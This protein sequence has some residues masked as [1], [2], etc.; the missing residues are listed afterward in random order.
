MEKIKIHWISKEHSIVGNALG[1]NTHN[2]FM[3]KH[4]QKIMDFDDNADIT[5]TIT[6]ADQFVPIPGKFNILFTMWEFLELPESYIKNLS[7]PDLIIVPSR[8]CKDLFKKYT[9]TPIEVCFEGVEA[10][11]YP[12]HQR[13]N[14]GKFRF[15]WVGAPNPRK[16]YPLIL[17]AVKWI[18]QMPNME[19]YIK[20]TVPKMSWIKTVTNAWKKRRS[21]WE[22]PKTDNIKDVGFR[23]AWLTAFIRCIRR[24]PKPYYSDRIKTFG[25]HK[26][27][28]FD[29]RF[30]S[31]DDLVSLYNSAN[32]FILPTFG[33]GWGLTLCEAMATGA[34][35]IATPITGCADF[36]DETVGYPIDYT[37]QKQNLENYDLETDGYV[38]DTRSMIQQMINVAGN[39]KEALKRGKKAHHRI[40]EKFTWE[41]SANRLNEIIRTVKNVD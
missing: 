25:P 37:I 11:K 1:Y 12:F 9:D 15:L 33:E 21:F 41:R 29:T 4:C 6:P 28:F 5:L 38:P 40:S 20:T 22:N 8:F 24:I 35:C 26:N 7:K 2:K 14:N 10:E 17:E 39:Y 36:F 32:C 16:G 13:D 27:V 3:R 23:K 34:P 18:E 30:L 19:L 31:F